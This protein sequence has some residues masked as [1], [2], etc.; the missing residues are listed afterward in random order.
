MENNIKK[1]K[2]IITECNDIEILQKGIYESQNEEIKALWDRKKKK[3][4]E[5]KYISE[6]YELNKKYSE[7]YKITEEYFQSYRSSSIDDLTNFENELLFFEQEIKKTVSKRERL[8]AT[9]AL[10]TFRLEIAKKQSVKIRAE[11]RYNSPNI[12]KCLFLTPKKFKEELKIW[13]E[14]LEES[15]SFIFKKLFEE[16]LK[17]EI[18]SVDHMNYIFN[19]ICGK[20]TRNIIIKMYDRKAKP[21]AMKE[22]NECNDIK[23][24]QN[25]FEKS[26]KGSQTRKIWLDRIIYLQYFKEEFKF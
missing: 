2:A 24:A 15:D 3:I 8:A 16:S 18:A 25:K 13:K 21:V 11:K 12:A 20:K 19:G 7:G 9:K 26:F 17:E 5:E 4:N 23:I 1:L 14:L 10:S 22:V 6:W